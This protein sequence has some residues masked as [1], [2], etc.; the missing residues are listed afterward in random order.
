MANDHDTQDVKRWTQYNQI[1][2]QSGQSKHQDRKACTK[3]VSPISMIDQKLL[4]AQKQLFIDSQQSK[5]YLTLRGQQINNIKV[6]V[7]NEAASSPSRFSHDTYMPGDSKFK[8]TA[9]I[10]QPYMSPKFSVK[11]SSQMIGPEVTSRN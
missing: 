5:K 9:N 8:I 1:Y 6:N 3:A 10:N 11:D 7:K 2:A 4:E